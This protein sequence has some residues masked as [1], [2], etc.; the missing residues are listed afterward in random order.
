MMKDNKIQF[1]DRSY[2]R[3]CEIEMGKIYSREK[4][5]EMDPT[6]IGSISELKFYEHPTYGDEAPLVCVINDK[7]FVSCFMNYPIQ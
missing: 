5:M 2:N 3:M 6:L 4:F 1:L 7:C